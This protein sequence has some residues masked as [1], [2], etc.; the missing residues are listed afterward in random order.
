VRSDPD[1]AERLLHNLKSQTQ[2]AIA[3]IRRLVYELRPPALD[4]VGLVSAIEQQAA[5]YSTVGGLRI[6]V[7]APERL[8][9]LPAA[10]EVAAYRIV[11]EALTNVARH[12]HAQHGTVRLRMDAGLRLEI[13]DDGCGLAREHPAGVGLT[14]MRERAAELGGTCVIETGP[15][16]GTRVQ[17][18]LPLSGKD[19]G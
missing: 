3:D 15:E 2:A 18:T 4:E 7:E 8:P 13:E 10:V 19:E 6:A 17:A 1:A 12:A 16:G 11:Q 14:S 5:R 9:P